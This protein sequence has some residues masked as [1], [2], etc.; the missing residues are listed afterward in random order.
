MVKYLNRYWYIDGRMDNG[1]VALRMRK[2]QWVRISMKTKQNKIEKRKEI[3]PKYNKI[4]LIQK[5]EKYI[6]N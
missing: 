2:E 4:K 1:Q 6:W 3:R 5:C